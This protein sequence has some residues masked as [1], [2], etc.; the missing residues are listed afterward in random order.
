MSTSARTTRLALDF[1]LLVFACASRPAVAVS[2]WPFPPIA[3]ESHTPVAVEVASAGKNI[4]C[5]FSSRSDVNENKQNVCGLLRSTSDTGTTTAA[6]YGR[7][8]TKEKGPSCYK[9]AGR[10]LG[11][12]VPSSRRIPPLRDITHHRAAYIER[13]SPDFFCTCANILLKRW[14][15]HCRIDVTI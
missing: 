7:E 15:E 8:G 13:G 2:S 4:F 11:Y 3:A 12:A 1:R 14:R 9:G 5:A 10:S 6:V